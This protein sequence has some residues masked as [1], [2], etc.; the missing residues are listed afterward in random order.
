MMTALY[1]S[2]IN[3]HDQNITIIQMGYSINQYSIFYINFYNYRCG[4]LKTV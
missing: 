4:P 1:K 3:P 2:H